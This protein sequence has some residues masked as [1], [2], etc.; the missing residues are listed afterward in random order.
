MDLGVCSLTVLIQWTERVLLP[1]ITRC[2]LPKMVQSQHVL[3]EICK[4]TYI[5]AVLKPLEK[6]CMTDLTFYWELF[7]MAWLK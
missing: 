6:Q 1:P 5:K 3:R 4:H 7:G 2:F